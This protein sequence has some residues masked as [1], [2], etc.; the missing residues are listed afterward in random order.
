LQVC[1]AVSATALCHQQPWP[2]A[3]WGLCATLST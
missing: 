3:L 2:P 1:Q